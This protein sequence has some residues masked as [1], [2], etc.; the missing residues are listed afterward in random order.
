MRDWTVL[1][2]HLQRQLFRLDRDGGLRIRAE[3]IQNDLVVFFV[4]QNFGVE[5]F[6]AEFDEIAFVRPVFVTVLVCVSMS[7][8]GVVSGVLRFVEGA[9]VALVIA[10]AGESR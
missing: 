7:V 8:L 2:G 1:A 10:A 6:F 5:L 4:E 9:V 3:Q